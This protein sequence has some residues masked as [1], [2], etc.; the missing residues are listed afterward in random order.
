MRTF[1]GFSTINRQYGNFKLYD[2][3]LAMRDL[4]N[5]L[6]TRRGERLMSPSYGSI[7]WDLLFDPLIDSVIALID[8]DCRRIVTKDPRLELIQVLVTESVDQQ[9]V[10]VTLMLRYLPTST[11]EELVATFNRNTDIERTEG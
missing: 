5:E 1:K 11:V 3:E 2:K 4:L 8:D 7:V 10:V 9:S 6:Y